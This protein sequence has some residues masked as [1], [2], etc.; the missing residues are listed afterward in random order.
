MKNIGEEINDILT[1]WDPLDVGEDIA[2]D[3]YRGYIPI[4]IKNIKVKEN[5]IH[6][7]EDIVKN[8]LEVGYDKHNYNHKN[9]LINLVNR[10]MNLSISS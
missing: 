1:E 8:D 3:E 4:I 10:L 2:G 7:L 6:C 5:L 9:D